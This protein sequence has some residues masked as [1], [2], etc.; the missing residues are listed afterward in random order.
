MPKGIPSP[1]T[2]SSRKVSAFSLDTSVI[3]A[4]GFRFNE[5]PLRHLAGQLPPWMTLWMTDVIV[6]EI[7]RHRLDYVARASQQVISGANELRRHIGDSF[8]METLSWMESTRSKAVNVF[9]DQLQH[10]L[11]SHSGIILEPTHPSLGTDIFN[12]YFQSYPP[13]GGGKDKKHEFPDAAALLSLD[14]MA[15]EKGISIIV[16]SKD[17]GWKAYAERSKNIFCVS[18]LTDLTSLFLSDTLEAKAVKNKIRDSFIKPTLELS[19]DIKTVIEKGLDSLSWRVVYPNKM[20][21]TV[22][23]EVIETRLN[24]FDLHADG[25]GVWITSAENDTCAVEIPLEANVFLRIG[26]FSK[27][28]FDF[29][30]EINIETYFIMIERQIQLKFIIDLNGDLLIQSTESLIKIMEIGDNRIDILLR[31]DELGTKWIDHSDLAFDDD[32]PF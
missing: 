4:A 27:E 11:R 25:L 13:F 15:T 21:Y 12:M 5:G 20:R 23:A 8:H 22:D 19:K 18:S 17:D 30:S 3:E 6:R 7:S 16:V 26:I 10:F 9:D 31:S 29:N 14:Y 1:D 24:S 2:L 32:I 28:N